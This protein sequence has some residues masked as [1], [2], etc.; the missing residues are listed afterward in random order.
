MLRAA[1]N[2]FLNAMEGV[3][4]SALLVSVRITNQDPRKNSDS[5]AFHRE[6]YEAVKSRDADKAE[7]LTEKLLNDAIRRLKENFNVER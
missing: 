5:V 4:Y 1:H 6:V 7:S 3:I 2:E